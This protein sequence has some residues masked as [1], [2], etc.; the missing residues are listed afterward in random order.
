MDLPGASD[1]DF[2]T[3]RVVNL[4]ISSNKQIDWIIEIVL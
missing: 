2:I 3:Q 1:Y 4:I